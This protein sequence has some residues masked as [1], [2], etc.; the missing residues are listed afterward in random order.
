MRARALLLTASLVVVSVALAEVA[1]AAFA[2]SST[3]A[4]T[5]SSGSLGTPTSV[6]VVRSVCTVALSDSAVVS[7]SQ[8][9]N[10]KASGYEVQRS[11]ISGGPYTTVGT[12]SG[13][14]TT[15]YTDSGLL[16][17]TTYYYVVRSTKNNWKSSV[18]SQVSV[19]TRN[20][21]CV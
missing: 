3:A 19:T 13:A 1:S 21:L 4:A 11:L 18:S 10:N 6:S 9:S 16:F 5:Y 17:S 15:S 7:W 20:P 12:V 14:S 8:P 2:S